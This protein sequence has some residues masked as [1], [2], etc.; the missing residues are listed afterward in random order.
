MVA[1]M[2]GGVVPGGA[3]R[4]KGADSATNAR[5]VKVALRYT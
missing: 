5:Y 2:R 4:M 1:S 3:Y